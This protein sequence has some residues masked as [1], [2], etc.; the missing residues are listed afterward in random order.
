MKKTV[1]CVVSVIISI[2]CFSQLKVTPAGFVGIATNSPQR[3]LHVNGSFL[4]SGNNNIF[5]FT[6]SNPGTEV[7]TSTDRIDF[8]YSPVG[9]N[10]L[11]AQQY[12]TQSDIST[13][14]NINPLTNGVQTLKRLNTYSYNIKTDSINLEK[15]LSFGLIAQEVQQ[16]LPEIVD[17]SKGI[18]LIN[19]DEFIPFLILSVQEQQ[20]QIE[21]LQSI[22]V[23]QENEITNLN[24]IVFECCSSANSKNT[25]VKESILPKANLLQNKP[26]PFSEETKINYEIT[27]SF[28][29]AKLII[30]NLNGN[31]IKAYSIN[32]IGIGEVI[33]NGKELV[34]GMYLYTLIIDNEIIDTK[35]M[36]LTN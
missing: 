7:G 8:W 9:H 21:L 27:T 17:T 33:I 28:E 12:Y 3:T 20:V 24:S 29:N 26:N 5:T 11:Y 19:Y 22:V 34:P 30:H 36:I 1:L 6:A 25:G 4:I 23:A 15:K 31:E 32:N 13:K 18:L 2:S 14:T 16:V 35:R 10:N